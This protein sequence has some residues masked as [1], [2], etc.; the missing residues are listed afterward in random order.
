MR[1]IVPPALC[2]LLG[3]LHLDGT[4]RVVTTPLPPGSPHPVGWLGRTWSSWDDAFFQGTHHQ[5]RLL[6]APL[7]C[8]GAEPLF[9]VLINTEQTDLAWGGWMGGRAETALAEGLSPILSCCQS[10]PSAVPGQGD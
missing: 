7:E 2:F 10:L 4:Q 1:S 3:P 6:P 8:T 5:L 9:V